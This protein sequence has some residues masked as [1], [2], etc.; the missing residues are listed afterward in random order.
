MIEALYDLREEI[1]KSSPMRILEEILRML[2]SGSSVP[3]LKNLIE[4]NFLSTLFPHLEKVLTKQILDT[5][6]SLLVDVDGSILNENKRS[7]KRAF[8]VSCIIFPIFQKHIQILYNKN[9]RKT[10]IG[11]IHQEAFNLTIY[12]FDPHIKITKKI[13]SEVA[14]ILYTQYIFTPITK[15][16]KKICKI[17]KS[18]YFYSALK[19]FQL[20]INIEPGLQEIYS[21]W[22]YYYTKHKE[23]M[24]NKPSPIKKGRKR[25]S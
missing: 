16:R 23:T 13:L 19:F 18:R 15:K 9:P 6:F 17:P 2:E 7:P 4:H 14:E 25:R 20:R 1:L 8:L 3:F 21:E 22:N 10:H 24:K 11:K 12:L 5:I